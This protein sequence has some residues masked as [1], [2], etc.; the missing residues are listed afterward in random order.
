M[1]RNRLYDRVSQAMSL[2][3]RPSLRNHD[4]IEAPYIHPFTA[5]HLFNSV[6]HRALQLFP[7]DRS[8]A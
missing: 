1:N 6:D 3:D 7:R 4:V 8:F 2:G 5:Q